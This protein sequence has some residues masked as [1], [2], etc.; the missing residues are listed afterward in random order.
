VVRLSG[1]A[2]TRQRHKV[3]IPDIIRDGASEP[4]AGEPGKAAV[5]DT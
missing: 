5:Q 3:A 2:I 4:G 1:V